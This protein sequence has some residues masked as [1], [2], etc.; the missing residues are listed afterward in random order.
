[1]VVMDLHQSLLF[2]LLTPIN[3]ATKKFKNIPSS[4]RTHPNSRMSAE[5]HPSSKTLNCAVYFSNRKLK[6]TFL[7][8][9]LWPY[10]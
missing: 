4:F 7:H 6:S 5:T 10:P 3:T 2:D 8:D 9:L 1:M